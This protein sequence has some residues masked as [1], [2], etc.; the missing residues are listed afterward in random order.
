MA[1]VLIAGCGAAVAHTNQQPTP[2]AHVTKH[3]AAVTPIPSKAAPSPTKVPTATVPA[4]RPVMTMPVQPAAP[5]T[6]PAPMVK[7]TPM[8]TL[9]PTPTRTQ[10]MPPAN[11]I[12]QGGGGDHDA[13]N[14]GGP[15]DG[16]GNI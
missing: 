12:P 6:P 5:T 14:S 4:P 7:P 13:D 9:T 1:G 8:V 11:G 16:D 10:H 3:A 15:S 2:S